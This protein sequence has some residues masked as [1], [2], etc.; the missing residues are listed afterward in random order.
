MGG[1]LGG[2][3]ASRMAVEV[4]GQ[5]FEHELADPETLLERAFRRANEEIHRAARSDPSLHGMGTTGV[6]LLIGPASTAWVAHVGDS[7]AYR[8]RGG[9]LT[10]IT[11]DH[12]WVFEEV[13]RGRI[14]ASDA[15]RHPLKNVLLQSIGTAMQLE[16][17]SAKIDLRPGDRL[18]LCSDGLWGEVEDAAIAQVLEREPPEAAVDALVELANASGG[19]DNVTVQVASLTEPG[20]RA[21][22]AIG[23]DAPVERPDAMRSE[24]QPHASVAHTSDTNR[25]HLW[26]RPAAIAAGL[27]AASAVFWRTCS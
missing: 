24:P 23:I 19:S 22:I 17:A 20:E 10:R 3:T 25:R 13:R 6:A 21:A 27:F 15:R 11:E 14:S 26:A 5:T 9:E 7:R 2:G 8:L 12:S 16:V 4:I 1:H 18:L